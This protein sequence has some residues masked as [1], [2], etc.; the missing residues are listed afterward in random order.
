L[1]SMVTIR[2]SFNYRLVGCTAL[3]AA[4]IWSNSHVFKDIRGVIN[5]IALHRR[6]KGKTLVNVTQNSET[7]LL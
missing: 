7:L 4:E 5:F 1:N 2:H 3:T 6:T